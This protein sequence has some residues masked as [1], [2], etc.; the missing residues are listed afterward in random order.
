[1]RAAHMVGR[2]AVFAMAALSMLDA[3]RVEAADMARPMPVKAMPAPAAPSWAGFYIGGHA[4]YAWASSDGD[5]RGEVPVPPPPVVVSYPFG[6][7]P[8]GA[9]LGAHL[10]YNFQSGSW[11]LSLEGDWSWLF[12]AKDTVADPGG[13]ARFDTIELFW[14]GHAR[15][16]IGYL[17]TSNT[18]AFIAGGAAFA[19]T[20]N[21]HYGP[22]GAG[23]AFW[24]DTRT[25]IGYSLGGGFEHMLNPNWLVRLEYLFDHFDNEAFIWAAGRYT[26]SDLTLNTVRLGISYRP[27]P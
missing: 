14:T 3:G 15:G 18:L 1:M 27:A 22:T 11:I 25:R 2:T 6:L 26:N 24:F 21:T 4:G 16:R 17:L 8:D 5:Y 12:D 10:G 20:R 19:S 9:T 23:G 13:S 7:R